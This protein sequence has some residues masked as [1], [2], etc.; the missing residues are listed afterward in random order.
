MHETDGVGDR[1]YIAE[2]LKDRLQMNADRLITE[3]SRLGKYVKDKVR[4]VRVK[5]SSLEGKIEIL[6]RAQM[7]KDI[8]SFKRIFIAPDMTRQQQAVDKELRLKLKEFRE[9]NE[10]DTKI[11]SGKIIQ[12]VDE[13]KGVVILYR[14]PK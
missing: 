10:P 7:L 3:V 8:Q 2:I 14:P 4:P 5:I 12:N 6:Q 9:G 1:D 13:G 11:K